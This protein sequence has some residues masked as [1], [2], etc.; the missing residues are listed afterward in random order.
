MPEDVHFRLDDPNAFSETFAAI[1]FAFLVCIQDPL[2][3]AM[4]HQEI[5]SFWDA[6]PNLI[7]ACFMVLK[8]PIIKQ[9]LEGRG[10]YFDTFDLDVFVAEIGTH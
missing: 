6:T 4:S 10:K 1:V 7:S 9:W 5:D 2:G 3:R 8:P